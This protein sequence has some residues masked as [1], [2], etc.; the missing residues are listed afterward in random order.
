MGLREA[1]PSRDRGSECG[2]EALALTRPSPGQTPWQASEGATLCRGGS[3][4]QGACP[5][6]SGSSLPQARLRGGPRAPPSP[7]GA[8]VSVEVVGGALPHASR[9]VACPPLQSWPQTRFIFLHNGPSLSTTQRWPRG[10]REGIGTR[11][12]WGLDGPAGRRRPRQ[13]WAEVRGRD[14]GSRAR[15]QRAAKLALATRGPRC[16]TLG[17]LRGLG[18]GLR[19]GVRAEV[20]WAPAGQAPGVHA[21]SADGG[22]GSP[23]PRVLLPGQAGAQGLPPAPVPPSVHPR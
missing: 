4:S 2:G 1:G 8:S 7:P 14:L 3:R 20:P 13:A 18:S 22:A 19:R 12:C 6:H 11:G 9:P 15:V 16:P 23:A 17:A 5:Q 21:R 10:Q